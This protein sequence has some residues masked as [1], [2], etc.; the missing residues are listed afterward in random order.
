MSQKPASLVRRLRQR[1]GAD[2]GECR[3]ALEQSGGDFERAMALLVVNAPAASLK[4]QFLIA[5]PSLDDAHF[6]HTV[7][8]MCE[9]NDQGA[10]GLV[11][12]RPTDLEL[13]S[14]LDQMGIA[15][16][17]M[18][19]SPPVYWG[20][21]VQPER[22][23]VVHRDPGGWDSCL[24]L[25][26][27]LY[28]TTSRDILVAIGRGEGPAEFLVALGYAGWDAGQLENEILLNSWLTV[29]ADL[30]IL[31][32]RPARERWQAAT[33]LLGVE[34]TQIASGAGHA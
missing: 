2:L 11:V 6:S 19:T 1:T 10:I 3:A 13:G 33:R 24:K 30:S 29:D 7:S 26:P 34:I 22:G 12:N 8:L 20:G 5:M 25:A 32:S 17:A 14:M 15:H 9:H 31:F 23:F 18:Q 4:N 27:R 21:P 28:V 16:E